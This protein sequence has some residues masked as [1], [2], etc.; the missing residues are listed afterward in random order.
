VKGVDRYRR[1]RRSYSKRPLQSTIK[2][3]SGRSNQR[4]SEE[5]NAKIEEI[6]YS[7]R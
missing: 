5:G 7:R 4:E 6:I 2:H 3:P 1:H